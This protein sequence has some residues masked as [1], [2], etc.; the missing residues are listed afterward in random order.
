MLKNPVAFCFD[1]NGRIYIAETERLVTSVYDMRGHLD[2][3]TNDL[4]CRTVEDRA[5]ML[6]KFAGKPREGPRSCV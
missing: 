6:K 3:Y 1:E 2:M 5:A 4:A